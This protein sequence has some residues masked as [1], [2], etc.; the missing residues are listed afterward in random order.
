MPRRRNKQCE[1]VN[2]P[3]H[4]YL[5]G[6]VNLRDHPCFRDNPTLDEEHLFQRELIALQRDPDALQDIGFDRVQRLWTLDWSRKSVSIVSGLPVSQLRKLQRRKQ[7]KQRTRAP[8]KTGVSKETIGLP[9]G[10][11][12]P[13]KFASLQ[14]KSPPELLHDIMQQIP[15]EDIKLLHRMCAMMASIG[16]E[17]LS[18]EVELV[19][20]RA[21]SGS[22][23]SDTTHQMNPTSS[24][25]E[26]EG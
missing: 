20:H 23:D 14:H 4:V 11:K 7:A 2:L 1:R 16:L 13:R 6:N 5:R 10:H 26:Y 9:R 22:I 25:A 12:A 17:N 24:N 21:S 8:V 15:L 19:L 3:E 18:A